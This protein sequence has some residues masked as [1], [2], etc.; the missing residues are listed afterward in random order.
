MGEGGENDNDWYKEAFQLLEDH[1]ISW[2]FWT[3][4]KVDKTN[5]PYSNQSPPGWSDIKQYIE[6]GPKPS[7][8]MALEIMMKFADNLL[9]DSCAYYPEVVEAIIRENTYQ[10]R[11]Q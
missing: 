11:T 5:S 6:G 10:R 3:W 7:R 2:N 1:D 8:E 4:K 9:L